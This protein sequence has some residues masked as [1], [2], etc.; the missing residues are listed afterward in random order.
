MKKILI[1]ILLLLAFVMAVACEN[2]E[3]PE[4]SSVIMP[5]SSE[6]IYEKLESQLPPPIEESEG[7]VKKQSFVIATDKKEVFINEEGASGSV[8][9]AVEKRNNFLFD[10]YGAQISVKEVKSADLTKSLKEAF[11]SGLHY[12]D[13]I[14]VS[15]KE[16]VKL[17]NAGLLSDM[18]KLPDFDAT[19]EY[20]DEDRSVGLATN[21]SLYMLA[22]P[23]VQYFEEE[24]AMFYNR[25]LVVKTAGQNPESLALQGKWTWD[26]FNEVCRASAPDVYNHSTS[27]LQNDVFG[28]GAYYNVGTLPL[29]MW[30]ASGHHLIENTYK[31]TVA[32][33]MSVEEVQAAAKPL[34][35]I[36]NTRGRLPLEGEDVAN[37]FKNGRLAF[38]VHKFSYFYTLRNENPDKYGFLPIPMQNEAQTGYR[39]LLSSDARVISMPV[40][41]DF[42]NDERRRFV[43]VVLAATCAAGGETVK[44][45]FVNEHIGTY[46]YNNEETVLFEM[47][48]DSA[49]FDFS[50]VYGSVIGEIRRPTTD[51]IVDYVEFGSAISSSISRSLT[52]FNKYS[53]EK[54]K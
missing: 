51:A 4:D 15:A 18:N 22:D 19:S 12:C 21:S 20:F 54:F 46:L 39:C 1:S 53:A 47:I 30:T 11:E 10:T 33:S 17:M 50:T 9:R 14:S 6:D 45:A 16:T 23:T 24:Y 44:T 31:S 8:N 41:M 26:T 42:Q 38:M 36:Y 43:S 32:L 28:Y 27:D 7:E 48:C 3:Y 52:A 25:D 49:T 29:V 37:A 5:E 35:D 2:V 34:R 40:T 13:M